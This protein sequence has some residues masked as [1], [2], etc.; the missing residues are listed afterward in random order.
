VLKVVDD[1]NI[2]RVPG[3]LGHGGEVPPLPDLSGRFVGPPACTLDSCQASTVATPPDCER[4]M[5]DRHES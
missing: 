2:A 4:A 5:E 3:H 1:D